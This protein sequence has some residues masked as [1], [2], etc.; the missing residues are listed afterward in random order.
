MLTLLAILPQR[1]RLIVPPPFAQESSEISSR[2]DRIRMV[3]SEDLFA[4]RQGASIEGFGLVV[5]ALDSEQL[6]EVVEARS[7][8]GMVGS[9]LFFLKGDGAVVEWRGLAILLL[10][11]QQESKATFEV[12]CFLQRAGLVERLYGRQG[13]VQDE[14]IHVGL[15]LKGTLK[16]FR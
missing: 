2:S 12:A 8:A 15:G 3:G 6:G 4:D 5:V 16:T 11:I 9:V 10:I 13:Q 14:R 7:G 1:C